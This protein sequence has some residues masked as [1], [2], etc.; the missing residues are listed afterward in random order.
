MSTS[1]GLIPILYIH[2]PQ[3][4]KPTDLGDPL[5]INLAAPAGQG[6]LHGSQMVN[7]NDSGDQM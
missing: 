2:G 4:M 1:M 3:K 7:P 6:F 5:T